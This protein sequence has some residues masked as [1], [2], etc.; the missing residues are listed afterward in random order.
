[1]FLN[2]LKE[3]SPFPIWIRSLIFVAIREGDTI[4]RDVVH[5][6]MPRID[7]TM[8]VFGNHICFSRVE[9]T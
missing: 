7:Q 1:M 6:F 9:N 5:M 3:V 2:R 8:W 4:E